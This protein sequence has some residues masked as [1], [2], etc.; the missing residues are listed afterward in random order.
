MNKLIPLLVFSFFTCSLFG[1]FVISTHNPNGGDGIKPVGCIHPVDGM[2]EVTIYLISCDELDSHIDLYNYQTGTKIDKVEL[3]EPE[4][5]NSEDCLGQAYLYTIKV[6]INVSSSINYDCKNRSSF[7]VELTVGIPDKLSN[8]NDESTDN[9][10]PDGPLKYRI[11]CDEEEEIPDDLG[12]NTGQRSHSSDSEFTVSPNPFGNDIKLGNVND[13]D[14]IRMTDMMGRIHLEKNVKV[15][16]S[17]E[18]YR[19]DTYDLPAGSFKISIYR[20]NRIEHVE[21]VLKF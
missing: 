12:T 2:A 18:E 6:T 14:I 19:I 5:F 20:N 16:N 1:Q 13:N 17:N 11:C 4:L 10:Y 9:R 3:P 15:S 8:Y 7:P 21:K